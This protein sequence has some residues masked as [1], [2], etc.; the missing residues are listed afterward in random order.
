[1]TDDETDRA[2]RRRA[3]RHLGLTGADDGMTRIERLLDP[4]SA[5]IVR[6]TLDANMNES[7]FDSSDRTHDQ[8][9]R[10]PGCTVRAA[11]CDAHHVLESLE[12]TFRQLELI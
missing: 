6:T 7:A 4:S 9:C 3:R 1:V 2:E 12:R 5:S 10:W 11:W 8:R